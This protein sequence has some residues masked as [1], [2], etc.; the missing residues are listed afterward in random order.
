MHAAAIVATIRN[1]S[2]NVVTKTK[3]DIVVNLVFGDKICHLIGFT[4]YQSNVFTP[5]SKFKIN[6]IL[7]PSCAV[8][9]FLQFEMH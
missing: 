9:I 5:L 3:F 7:H 1:M 8:L 4:T 2:G 6:L